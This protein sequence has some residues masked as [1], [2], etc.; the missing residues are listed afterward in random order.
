MTNE[1]KIGE[2]RSKTSITLK[3]SLRNAAI[4]HLIDTTGS[5]E[6]SQAVEIALTEWISRGQQGREASAEAPVTER[7]GSTPKAQL[8]SVPS[9]PKMNE[10]QRRRLESAIWQILEAYPGVTAEAPKSAHDP[11]SGEKSGAISG[12]NR[13]SKRTALRKVD[14]TR[15][16]NGG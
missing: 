5:T 10:E 12:R 2:R 11:G 3:Q 6:I 14:R 7:P 1:N 16:T 13:Q 4:K 8:Q 9:L 15:K